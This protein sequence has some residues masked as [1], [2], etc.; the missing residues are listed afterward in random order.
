MLLT[1]LA[2]ALTAA[3]ATAAESGD[4]TIVYNGKTI[5]VDDAGGKTVVSVYD[6]IDG[7]LTKTRETTFAGGQEV[8]QVYITSPFMPLRN[9]KSTR[10]YR[11]HIPDIYFGMST[12]SGGVGGFKSSAGLHAKAEYSCDV[13]ITTFGMAIPFNRMHTFGVTTAL[14]G[15]Y[16]RHSLHKNY[17]L[18]N[19]DGRTEVVALG[20]DENTKKSYLSYWYLRVPVIFEWQK[21]IRGTEAFAG[22][23]MSLEYRYSEHSRFKGGA[24]G[25]I[26][27][28]SD[29][30]MNPVG[31]NLEAQVG[32][33]SFV[34][35]LRTALTPLMN[36]DV[37]PRCYPVGLTIGL[38]L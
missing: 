30:N 22:I 28:T 35:S 16:K 14:Q 21:H 5:T 32:F 24:S 10:R 13:G 26:T 18:Y 17:S 15:G 1:T 12:M 9:K 6:S 20:D 19:I 33:S 11:D 2:V 4:T 27:P 3:A 38:K 34:V 31:L 29:L 25:T 8:E 23:G 36:T 7:A 37:A